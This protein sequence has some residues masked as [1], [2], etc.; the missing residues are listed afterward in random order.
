MSIIGQEAR[1]RSSGKPD[2]KLEENRI[3]G[4]IRSMHSTVLSQRYNCTNIIVRLRILIHFTSDTN[5][6]IMTL[7][8]GRVAKYPPVRHRHQLFNNSNIKANSVYWQSK[9]IVVYFSMTVPSRCDTD[10]SAALNDNAAVN[11]CVSVCN[12]CNRQTQNILSS[13]SYRLSRYVPIT[14]LNI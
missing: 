5:E 9:L 8:N 14:F 7:V 12:L 1:L 4:K 6:E 3:L 2:G 13:I 11:L 10:R